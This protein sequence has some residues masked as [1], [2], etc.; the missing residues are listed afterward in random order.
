MW[1]E[2]YYWKFGNMS[3]IGKKPINLPVGVEVAVKDRTVV[4]KGPK[5]SLELEHVPQVAVKKVDQVLTVE[6]VGNNDNRKNALWGLTRA[7]L[8]NLVTG[9]SE[10]FSKTL[11][12]SGVGYKASIQG[13]KLSLLVGFTHPVEFNIPDGIAITVDKNLIKVSGIDKRLV[14]QV[15]A[16][17]RA[18]RP[19]EPYKGKGIK[20]VDEIVRRKAGKVVKAAT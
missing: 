2:N 13:H 6:V 17:L 4:V 7:L 10:G 14:G 11:E 18:V 8:A 5:G 12:I 20:Y 1:V 16:E 19:P 9:V 15:A 3:R